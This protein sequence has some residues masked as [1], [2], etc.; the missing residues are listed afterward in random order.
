V[1][2]NPFWQ[3]DFFTTLQGITNEI[4]IVSETPYFIIKCDPKL[5]IHLVP[6]DHDFSAPALVQ[7]QDGYSE[8]QQQL[9]HLWEDIWIAKRAQV[10]SR[11][12]SLLGL[13]KSIHG[14]KVKIETL[15]QDQSIQFLDQYHLQGFIKAKFHYGLL[16]DNQIVSV[17]SFSETRPMKSKGAAYRSAELVRF[18]TRERY[19]VVGGF[20]KL[21]KHF[22]TQ[23]KTNDLMTYADRDWSIGNGY[24]KLGFALSQVTE[25][26]L[27]YLH[28]ESLIRYFPHRLPKATISAFEAQK[29]LNLDDFLMAHGF[30]KLFNT[31]NLK[32][33]LYF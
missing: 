33:H 25:P 15:T 14:R 32:Y 20:S 11:I 17:A 9:V 8:N 13:N 2:L 10:L 24:E 16:Y 18:A 27:I 7:L 28:K 6:L 30:V 21:I 23:I 19:T 26:A 1:D 4:Q 3:K 12:R 31:G 29:T 22:T 5:L